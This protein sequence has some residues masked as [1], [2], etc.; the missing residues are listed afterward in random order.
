V[1]E[2]RRHHYIPQFILRK[3]ANRRQQ[4]WL[5]PLGN[6]KNAFLTSVK[7]AFQERDLNAIYNGD[8]SR[9][10]RI[11]KA[12]SG[13][14]AAAAE[15]VDHLLNCARTR[16][17]AN[18][19]ETA[20]EVWDRYLYYQIKRPPRAMHH[21]ERKVDFERILLATVE[22]EEDAGRITADMKAA[23]LAPASKRLL[24]QNA[25]ALARASPP[26]P[27]SRDLIAS[28]GLRIHVI[29][30]PVLG[31]FVIG[32]IG[33]TQPF[34][35]IGRFFTPIAPDVALVQTYQRHVVDLHPLR[36]RAYVRKMNLSTARQST[37]I[38]GSEM[39]L[40]DAI[41]RRL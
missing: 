12:F 4:I 36:D 38:A 35:G 25:R 9:D 17:Q 28:C 16:A 32:D 39:D 40:L 18:L 7:N 22:D 30:D 2:P 23:I 24:H 15:I 31:S 29:P 41:A 34:P 1:T 21:T 14:E 37:M 26:A 10:Q 33:V 6:D 27:K 11:E 20:W 19:P 5:R 8:G 3:F 13:I